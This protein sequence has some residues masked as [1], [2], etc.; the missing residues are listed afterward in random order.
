MCRS[1]AKEVRIVHFVFQLKLQISSIVTDLFYY[2]SPWKV[3]SNKIKV[4]QRLFD[5]LPH[6]K[7]V[8][9]ILCDCENHKAGRG[10]A[11][12]LLFHMSWHLPGIAI[13]H[14]FHKHQVQDIY[15]EAYTHMLYKSLKNISQTKVIS[16][17]CQKTVFWWGVYQRVFVGLMYT[18]L[19]LNPNFTHR[20]VWGTHRRGSQEIEFNLRGRK[21]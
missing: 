19:C 14:P 13:S 16:H 5:Q 6:W 7:L 15:S 3:K 10:K 21:T 4:H 18:H 1:K 9:Y 2:S 11:H 12:F 8:Y 20:S 17:N